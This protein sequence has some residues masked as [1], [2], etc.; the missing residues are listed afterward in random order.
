MRSRRRILS[1]IDG[2]H[3]LPL[4]KTMYWENVNHNQYQGDG[5][6]G[7]PQMLPC[8]EIDVERWIS[9]NYAI[10]YAEDAPDKA[11][12]R[13]R[14]GVH[15]WVDDYQFKRCWEQS[16]KYMEL[17]QEYGAVCSP[18]FS[19][20]D[21]FPLPI[22]AYNI[23][24]NAWLAR[25]WAEHGIKVV[26]SVLWSEKIGADFCW[27]VY[28]KHSVLAISSVGS[29]DSKDA[30]AWF[31]RGFN[32]MVDNLEPI[33]V[34]FHGQIPSECR[35]EKMMRIESNIEKMKKRLRRGD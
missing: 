9:F 13:K 15:F 26:P 32:K 27:N 28:P 21:D 29:M 30:G 24:K 14:T 33:Q 18:E 1:R 16:R 11:A 31:M 19:T 4:R 7:I 35:Y 12:K 25:Y 17:L 34:L 10:T 20:Y 8:K 22:I 5:I 2:E 6:L 23:Y 3:D